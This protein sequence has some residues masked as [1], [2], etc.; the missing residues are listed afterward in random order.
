MAA[1]SVSTP[2]VDKGKSTEN[3]SFVISG[4][5]VRCKAAERRLKAIEG[6][7]AIVQSK[8]KAAAAREDFLLNEIKEAGAKLLGN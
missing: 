4:L 8:Q 3:E 2:S 5:R 7:L 1:S 6:N